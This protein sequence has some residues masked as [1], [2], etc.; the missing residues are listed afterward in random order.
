MP[1]PH[2]AVYGASKAY[3]L[4]FSEALRE[5]LRG[6]GVSVTVLC[7]GITLTDFYARGGMNVSKVP[8]FMT[9]DAETVARV[10]YRGLMKNKRVVIPGL[11]NKM[12]ALFERSCPN[13]LLTRIGNRATAGYKQD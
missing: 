10:G 9:M 12:Y 7:P 11:V 8:S 2:Q 13:G 4:S 3:V 1:L 6:S 5:E